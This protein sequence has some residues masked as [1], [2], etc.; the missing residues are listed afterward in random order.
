MSEEQGSLPTNSDGDQSVGLERELASIRVAPTDG[1]SASPGKSKW[2]RPR[3]RLLDLLL[4]TTLVGAWMPYALA[5]RQFESLESENTSLRTLAEF[6]VIEDPAKLHVLK[7]RNH[8]YSTMTWKVYVPAGAN[9]ELRFATEQISSVEFPGSFERVTLTPGEHR[10]AM[11][12]ENSST[13]HLF[14]VYVDQTSV[15]TLRHPRDWMSNGSS[16]STSTG[17]EL[18]QFSVGES[19]TL[20]RE[21]FSEDLPGYSTFSSQTRSEIPHK[22]SYLWMAPVSLAH[23]RAGKFVAPG[24]VGLIGRH[25]WG[26]R[27]GIRISLSRHA[28]PRSKLTRGV[29]GIVHTGTR[30]SQRLP[31]NELSIKTR[32]K[33]SEQHANSTTEPSGDGKKGL[34]LT[35]SDSLTV[36]EKRWQ[37]AK[38]VISDDGQTQTVY[39]HPEPFSNGAQ[40]IIEVRFDARHPNRVGFRVHAQ[41]GDA[42]LDECVLSA[43][44]C[45]FAQ[46]RR[47]ELLDDKVKTVTELLPQWPGEANASGS[48]VS[49]WITLP[50]FHFP[51]AEDDSLR[52]VRLTTD[53][54]DYAKLKYAA[55]VG[56]GWQYQAL[57]AQQ[58]WLFSPREEVTVALRARTDYRNGNGPIPGGP[59]WEDCELRTPLDGK[60][61]IWFEVV[62]GE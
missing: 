34:E 38:G 42:E 7:L 33:G 47:V 58:S 60:Q 25:E 49:S 28:F 21:W 45:S 2:R 19:V 24:M 46:L 37:G 51:F 10:I 32:V 6:L 22:G 61:W 29:I 43:M 14:Q 44:T 27:E 40:P 11:S 8:R 52:R 36:G 50:G 9:Y 1:K 56:R 5:T 30:L 20:R 17:D 18:E 48:S 55:N 12:H 41:D 59:A 23:P 13:G 4:L 53:V 15:I 35:S 39:L 62:P 31:L 57:P 54:D 3:F 26:F 16:S